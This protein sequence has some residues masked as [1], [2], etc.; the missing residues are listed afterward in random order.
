MPTSKPLTGALFALFFLASGS[1]P[2]EIGITARG[3]EF[4]PKTVQASVGDILVFHFEVN[5][6]SVVMGDWSCPCAPVAAPAG[7]FSGFQPVPE[8]QKESPNVFR[9]QIN[10]TKPLVFYCS[11]NEGAHCK[12]G[13]AGAVNAPQDQLDKY[14]CNATKI[15]SAKSPPGIFGG[16][17]DGPGASSVPGYKPQPPSTASS[18]LG[19]GSP[20][21]G[22]P[23]TS[24]SVP[25]LATPATPPPSPEPYGTGART[26]TG[27]RDGTGTG[28]G[29]APGAGTETGA[30]GTETAQ[31]ATN[32]PIAPPPQTA[33]TGTPSG[34]GGVAPT[35]SHTGT[36]TGTGVAPPGH[37]HPGGT[38]T[39]PGSGTA[40]DAPTGTGAATSNS[41]SRLWH[42]AVAR[43]LGI[44][45]VGVVMGGII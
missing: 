38:A 36:G 3:S 10:D 21:A 14:I 17:L 1:S 4:V 42:G 11:Q 40:T 41:K 24:A 5:N 31:T 26:G 30:P 29:T 28:T 9:V 39:S 6:H 33:G 12:Q 18:G 35:P 19:D 43:A 8:G 2:R 44:A 22:T 20:G 13:M 25:P 23:T 7:F 27:A 15:T 45:V 32:T 37:T 16:I 34:P